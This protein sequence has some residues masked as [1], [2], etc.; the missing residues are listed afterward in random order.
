MRIREKLEQQLKIA[1][2]VQ[3][4]EKQEGFKERFYAKFDESVRLLSVPQP[5]TLR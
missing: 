3:D 5:N 4:A 2:S 1:L